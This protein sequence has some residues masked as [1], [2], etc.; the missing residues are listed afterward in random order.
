MHKCIIHIYTRSASTFCFVSHSFVGITDSA[1]M[2][3]PELLLDIVSLSFDESLVIFCVEAFS[4]N[5]R[6]YGVTVDVD[7][8]CYLLSG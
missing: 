5:G 7:Q 8:Y 6:N 4:C 2:I 3:D 1:A